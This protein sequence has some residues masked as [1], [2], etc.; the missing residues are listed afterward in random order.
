M[1][2]FLQLSHEN[3]TETLIPGTLRNR[4]VKVGQ[5]TAPAAE[6]LDSMMNTFE[7]L[8]TKSVQARDA[9]RVIYMMASH[10]RLMWIHPFLDG[11]GRTAR[12]ALDGAFV[13][14]GMQGYGLW[15]LSRGLARDSNT[16]KTLL[17]HADMP[18]QGELDGKGAL[19]SKALGEFVDF[20]LETALD[21]IEYM[22]NNLK[23]EV[24]TKRL[25]RYVLRVNDGLMDQDP[26]PKHTDK[27]FRHLLLVGECTRGSVADITG[28]KERTASRMIAELL[29]RDYLA[30]DSRVAPIRLQIRASMASYLFPSLV[31]E[32]NS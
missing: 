13:S 19:S 28:V 23:L 15:N 30:A 27:L 26:L 25:D 29:K 31:P 7:H 21:Q 22:N 11:N 12:L 16:Y 10:H 2:D 4:L 18:R 6:V 24:L 17:A 3:L 20:M 5:H 14:M 8:Y 1:E 9:A 32:T